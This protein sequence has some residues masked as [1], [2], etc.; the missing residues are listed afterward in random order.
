MLFHDSMFSYSLLRLFHFLFLLILLLLL[1]SSC[2]FS[3]AKLWAGLLAPKLPQKFPG[4]ITGL[5]K[6]RRHSSTF[7][8]SYTSKAQNRSCHAKINKKNW[9]IKLKWIRSPHSRHN[10]VYGVQSLKQWKSISHFK[11]YSWSIKQL[12]IWGGVDII[13]KNNRTQWSY[14]KIK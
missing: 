11:H 2:K 1:S 14:L 5:P 10:V 13:S 7:T 6:T 8:M 3:L 4:C 12:Y 9:W